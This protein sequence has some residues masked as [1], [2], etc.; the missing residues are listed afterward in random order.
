MIYIDRLTYR[1][2]GAEA[3]ILDDLSLHV[4]EG[5]FLL[6]MG[7]SGGRIVSPGTDVRIHPG[8]TVRGVRLNGEPVTADIDDGRVGFRVPLGTHTIE[9]VE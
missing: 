5:E 7:P 8:R 9:W 6:V 2:P 3:P 4:D 1:Y